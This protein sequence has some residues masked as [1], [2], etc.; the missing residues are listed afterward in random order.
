VLCQVGTRE[1]TNPG[2]VV[3]PGLASRLRFRSL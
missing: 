2:I 3:M 1:P